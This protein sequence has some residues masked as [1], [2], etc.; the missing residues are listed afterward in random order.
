MSAILLAF[1]A[2]ALREWCLN[3]A[4]KRGETKQ[5][6]KTEASTLLAK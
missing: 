2:L 4:Q 5:E 6:T 1:A 3:R